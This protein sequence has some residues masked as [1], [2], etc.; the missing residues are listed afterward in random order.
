MSPNS[1][2]D[3]IGLKYGTD[4]ASSANNYL[5]FY[6]F[7]FAP[8][9]YTQLTVLEIGVFNGASTKTWEEYFPESK[10]IGAD[11]NPGTKR[12]EQG[13]VII[14]QLDQSNIEELTRVASKHGPFD[15]IIED[16]SHMWEHQ[17]TSLR[18]L[19]PFLKNDGIYVVEDL[20]TNYGSLKTNYK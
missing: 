16:G 12:F 2:L 15:I 9:R 3:A 19:F 5:D 11:I 10:I 1:T 18:T 20:H 7:F 4:K 8:L 13:R 6:E 17:I 14:E